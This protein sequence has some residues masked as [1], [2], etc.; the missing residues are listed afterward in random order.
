[1]EIK[2]PK[3]A[4]AAVVTAIV[5]I[6]VS[7][8]CGVLAWS[9]PACALPPRPAASDPYRIPH[10]GELEFAFTDEWGVLE[11]L[12]DAREVHDG[13]R[14]G[15]PALTAFTHG[16]DGRARRAEVYTG[17]NRGWRYVFHEHD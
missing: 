7:V 15:R 4:L 17:E 6:S 14:I 16:E 2:S 11:A 12:A 1:M 3:V 9:L 13:A 8:T 5:L 10:G